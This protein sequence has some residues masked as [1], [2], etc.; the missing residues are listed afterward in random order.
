[1]GSNKK[2]VTTTYLGIMLALS[3]AL[4]FFSSFVPGIELTLYALASFFIGFAI[5]EEGAKAGIML[6]VATILLSLLIVP[7]KLGLIPYILLF[8]LYGIIKFYIEKCKKLPVEIILKLV[9]FNG[10]MAVG[11][12]F[13]K[14]MFM[15]DIVLP[16]IPILLIV[17]GVELIFLLYD[18]LYTQVI[19]FYMRNIRKFKSSL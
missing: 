10:I 1:M 19:V 12:F 3:V 5:V 2:I 13:F 14:E 11:L 6:Y 7:N 8:G 16:Q 4:L 15:M 9:F 18:Y 17:L